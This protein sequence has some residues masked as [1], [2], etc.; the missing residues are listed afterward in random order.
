M[1]SVTAFPPAI[2]QLTSLRIL[3]CRRNLITDIGPVSMLPALERL[4]VN[5]NALRSVSLTS[6]R[7]M[8]EIDLGSNDI[9]SISLLQG[10]IGSPPTSLTTLDLSH[11]KLS[12]LDGLDF[13]WMPGLQVV[14]VDGNGFRALPPSVRLA[15]STSRHHNNN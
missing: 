13:G 7:F 10:P 4:S 15:I 2:Y 12:S 8:R 14:R 5:H 9:T 3:D 6:G 1:C 11:A